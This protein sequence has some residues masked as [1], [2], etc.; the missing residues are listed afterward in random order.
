MRQIIF[1]FLVFTLSVFSQKTK[2]RYIS[3]EWENI[4]EALEYLV[5]ISDSVSF[6]KVIHQEK[7]VK[8]LVRLE[9]NP[10]YKFGRIAAF[11]KNNIRGEFSD[12]FEIE[13]RIVE[14]EI[15]KPIPENIVGRD[16]KIQLFAN[17]SASGKEVSF[18]KINN[19]IWLTYHESIQLTKEGVNEVFYYSIDKLGN[20]EYPQKKEFIL[21]TE[22]PKIEIKFNNLISES[23]KSYLINSKVKLNIQAKDLYSGIDTL[24]IFLNTNE[25]STELELDG[26][27]IQIPDEFHGKTF[28][29]A[30]FAKDRLGNFTTQYS[31]LRYD[32]S[33]P[34]ISL[35]PVS[36]FDKNGNYTI[37]L[38]IL[39]EDLLSGIESIYYSI[40]SKDFANYKEKIKFSTPGNYEVKAYSVDKAGN[41]S[42]TVIDKISIPKMKLTKR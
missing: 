20:R 25:K 11:D 41:V 29:L 14:P 13:Q 16:H 5:Q 30:V 7:T 22:A 12:V 6:K 32:N 2:S 39:A 3:I 1:L 40:D 26:D 27:T 9:P 15:I 42:E 31:F 36:S 38:E 34:T 19:G 17:D 24:K 8:S 21:D 23:S 37:E 33:L 35:N 18:Y 10:K 28:E 4:P